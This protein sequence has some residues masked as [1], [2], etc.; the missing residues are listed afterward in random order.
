MSFPRTRAEGPEDLFAVVAEWADQGP[1][2]METEGGDSSYAA[3]EERLHKI[4]A[5]RG[6]LRACIVRLVYERGNALVLHDM[7]RM[8]VEVKE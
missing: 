4:R 3:A 1:I 8:H 7:K 5:Q 2:L 6:F